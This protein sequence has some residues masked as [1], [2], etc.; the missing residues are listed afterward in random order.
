M[1]AHTQQAGGWD[2]G[3]SDSMARRGRKGYPA[4]KRAQTLATL[5]VNGGDA[6]KTARKEKVGLRT[7]YRWQQQG[8]DYLKDKHVSELLEGVVKGLLVNSPDPS[9]ANLK[10]WGIALGILLDKWMIL[11]GN[12]TKRVENVSI[13]GRVIQLSDREYNE[14][15]IQAQRILELEDSGGE[16]TEGIVGAPDG[17]GETIPD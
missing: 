9:E 12:P 10:D 11:G 3:N 13:D 2:G 14:A 5:A 15:L 6:V 4:E 7:V 16:D 17:E 1:P 8:P